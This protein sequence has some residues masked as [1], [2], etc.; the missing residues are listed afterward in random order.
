MTQRIKQTRS[1]LERQSK[2]PAEEKEEENQACV[3]D[4]DMKPQQI[5]RVQGWRTLIVADKHE[6]ETPTASRNTFI[7]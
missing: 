5:F 6:L 7:L 2:E 1:V 3:S 4:R